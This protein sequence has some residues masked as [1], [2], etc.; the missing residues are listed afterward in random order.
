MI[1]LNQLDYVVAVDTY[2]HLGHA[3][4]GFFYPNP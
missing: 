1:T 2:R 3:A 4:E